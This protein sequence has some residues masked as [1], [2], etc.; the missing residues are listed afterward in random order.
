MLVYKDKK[1]IL[2]ENDNDLQVN[3]FKKNKFEQG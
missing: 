3:N 2:I 1:L